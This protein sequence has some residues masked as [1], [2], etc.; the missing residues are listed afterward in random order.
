MHT[1]GDVSVRRALSTVGGAGGVD[2]GWESADLEGRE[3]LGAEESG[4]DVEAD[5][6]VKT[7]EGGYARWEI[8]GGYHRGR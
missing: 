7:Q 2:S 1:I 4:V 8:G 5:L 3:G 6:N